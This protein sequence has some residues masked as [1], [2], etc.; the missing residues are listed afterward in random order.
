MN[1]TKALIA[2]AL[3][4]ACISPV[5]AQFGPKLPGSGGGSNSSSVSAADIDAYLARSQEAAVMIGVASV[6]L[7]D[8]VD[9]KIDRAGSSATIKAIRTAKNLGAAES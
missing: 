1:K 4:C 7:K 5:Q 2:T 9:G 6:L 8:A 3:L